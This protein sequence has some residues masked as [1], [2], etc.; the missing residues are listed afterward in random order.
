M[1]LHTNL[2]RAVMV[3]VLHGVL[4]LYRLDCTA[5]YSY[6]RW[7]YD[8]S[9]PQHTHTTTAPAPLFNTTHTHTHTPPL[10]HLAHHIK[11]RVAPTVRPACS[12]TTIHHP[13]VPQTR[14][15]PYCQPTHPANH[16]SPTARVPEMSCGSSTALVRS[17]RTQTNGM[18]VFPLGVWVVLGLA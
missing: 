7:V 9:H 10:S 11:P 13:S 6:S 16:T 8:S 15:R 18:E 17:E 14:P 3:M 4:K 1:F 2:V 5:S 12:S